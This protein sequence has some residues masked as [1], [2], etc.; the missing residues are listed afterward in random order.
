MQVSWDDEIPNMWK[1]KKCLKP[2]TIDGSL[3][4]VDWILLVSCWD[5]TETLVFFA[6]FGARLF[7]TLEDLVPFF[8]AKMR[9]L[10]EKIK[11]PM[12]P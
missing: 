6:G 10:P 1:N 5:V 12:S 9:M 7:R 3:S 8:L 2:P 4:G 11:E